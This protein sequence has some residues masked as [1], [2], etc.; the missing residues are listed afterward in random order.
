MWLE[1]AYNMGCGYPIL[2]TDRDAASLVD[3]QDPGRPSPLDICFEMGQ[4]PVVRIYTKASNA[5]GWLWDDTVKEATDRL[6]A[7]G[8]RYVKTWNE[9]NLEAEWD[10][11]RPADWA[12]RVARDMITIAADI[13]ARGGIPILPPMSVGAQY[14]DIVG[15][16][17]EVAPA[18]AVGI[19]K[20]KWMLGIHAYPGNHPVGLSKWA[21]TDRYPYD[22]VNQ[23]GAPVSQELYDY[24]GGLGSLAWEHSRLEDVNQWRAEDKN[25]GDTMLEDDVGEVA[26]YSVAYRAM[27]SL[28][29]TRA[30]EYGLDWPAGM[31]PAVGVVEGGCVI[32]DRWDR[33]YPKNMGEYQR[34]VQVALLRRCMGTDTE[35]DGFYNY[36][37]NVIFG[38]GLW[39]LSNFLMGCPNSTWESQAMFS[40]AWE[41]FRTPGTDR[42]WCVDA[43][44]EERKVVYGEPIEPPPDPEPPVDPPPDPEPQPPPGEKPEGWRIPSTLDPWISYE[45]ALDVEPGNSYFGLTDADWSPYDPPIIFID[46]R[47]PDGSRM[48]GARVRVWWDG[49]EHVMTVPGDKPAEFPMGGHG[50]LGAYRV[51][52]LDFPSDQVWG[53][54]LGTPDQPNMSVHT[55]TTLRYQF[56]AK[57]EP[58]EPPVDPPPS[59]GEIPSATYIGARLKRHPTNPVEERPLSQ[60]TRAIFHHTGTPNATPDNTTNYW[61]DQK[62]WPTGPYTIWI[63]PEGEVLQ[64]F[65]LHEIGY[66][67]AS[68][69]MDSVGIV[70]EGI[71]IDGVD[72][73]AEQLAAGR[74]VMQELEAL[75]KREL[76]I[77]GHKE[78]GITKCPGDNWEIWRA[79]LVPDEPPPDPPE[80]PDENE[81]RLAAKDAALLAIENEAKAAQ[82]I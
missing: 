78:V 46:V 16:M 43:L 55:H 62:G 56:M 15:K 52:V 69:N 72:P 68:N 48:P 1:R 12:E 38:G 82:E 36:P 10:G 7:K 75:L 42:L 45:P 27:A 47:G 76:A 63:T 9:P 77:V 60:I 79:E 6:V 74:Q 26:I 11:G 61:V 33:R 40:Y 80:P 58:V 65:Y 35:R 5:L 81:A 23:A 57:Q 50:L 8:V 19:F 44:M 28:T 59:Q 18:A 30:K 53:I 2:L 3:K 51:Q 71:F 13:Q 39:I 22:R 32:G 29:S 25:P 70:L 14:V 49:G 37:P 17:L 66:H 21:Q 41:Q 20:K 24:L 34:D 4:V 31:R 73:T 67:A 54:G 64:C